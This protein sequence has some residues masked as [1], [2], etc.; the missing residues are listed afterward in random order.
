MLSGLRHGY[1]VANTD[2]GHEEP[3]GGMAAHGGSFA[4]GHP[5]Q[6]VDYAYRANHLMIEYAKALVQARYGKAPEHSYWVGCSL[7]GLEGLIEAKRYPDDLDGIVV[8]APPN[9]ITNF[10]ALQLWP[11]WLIAQDPERLIPESKYKMVHDAVLKQCATPIGQAQGFVDDPGKCAFDPATLLCKDGDA[12]DC[13]TPK[14]L[15]L[16]KQ[17]YAGPVNRLTGASI[18]PGP[19]YGSETDMYMMA[20]G[21]PFNVAQD[22]FSY[23]AFAN[24]E[25]RMT[26]MQWGKDFEA[27]TAKIGPLLHVDSEL[28]PFVKRGGKLLLYIGWNDYYNPKELIGYYDALIK[29]SGATAKDQVKLFALPGMN[30]CMGGAG[31]DTFNKLAAI[32]TWGVDGKARYLGKGKP[33]DASSFTCVQ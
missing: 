26:D 7:G 21:K 11:G 15:D 4:L 13:L 19:A 20:N 1:A 14:Q 16:L 17:T 33:E 6:L 9:P 28:A 5:E 29:N 10:N 18:F 25:W 22:M 23:V 32:D 2:T 30:H 31:C 12:A 27:A 3:K 8:G 24:P